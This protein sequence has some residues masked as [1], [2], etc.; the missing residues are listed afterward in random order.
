VVR[1]SLDADAVL[2]LL[3][4][5][6][7]ASLC[8]DLKLQGYKVIKRK[9]DI[10]DPIAMVINIKDKFSN[11][12]DLLMGIRGL[13]NEA[14]LRIQNVNFMGATINIISLEDFIAMKIFAGNPIDIQDAKGVLAVSGKKTNLKLLQKLVLDYGSECV[15]RFKSIL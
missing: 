4:S 12:V 7:I 5:D 13:G 6:D 9:G 11:R 1:A 8:E 2:S 14:F 15:E 3:T 10:D